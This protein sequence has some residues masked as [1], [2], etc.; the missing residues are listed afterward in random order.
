MSTIYRKHTLA[1]NLQEKRTKQSDLEGVCSKGETSCCLSSMQVNL[2]ELS[3]GFVISP[4]Y[5]MS[6]SMHISTLCPSVHGCS[7][8]NLGRG[9]IQSLYPY[10]ELSKSHN[11]LC[12]ICHWESCCNSFPSFK[13][14]MSIKRFKHFLPLNCLCFFVVKLN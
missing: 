11:S 5:S 8:S 12:N 9:G 10:L 6:S 7:S 1:L 14:L 4:F 13:G 2:K 3:W